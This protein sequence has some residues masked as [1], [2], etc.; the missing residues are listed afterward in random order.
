MITEFNA[1]VDTAVI[2]GWRCAVCGATV[3]IATPYPFTCPR[4]TAADRHHVLHPL[5]VGPEPARLDDPNP[6]VAYGPRLGVVGVRPG[7]RDDRAGLR[8]A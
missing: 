5:T 6:F 7:Q 3:D 1:R 8:G 2:V 4:A